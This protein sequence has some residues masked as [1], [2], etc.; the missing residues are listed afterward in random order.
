[1]EYIPMTL[2][3]AKK[4][5]KNDSIVLVAV[6]DLESEDCNTAFIPKKF[7]DCISLI[8]N[9]KTMARFCDDFAEHLRLFTELQA[10]PINYEPKGKLGT[11]L[12]NSNFES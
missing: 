10:D 1:M 4:F 8:N 11:I 3:E 6:Q 5:T 2:E 9:A 12:K 7:S